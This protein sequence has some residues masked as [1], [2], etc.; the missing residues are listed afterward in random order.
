MSASG[1][2]YVDFALASPALFRLVFG[3][4]LTVHGSPGLEAAGDAALGHLAADL[5]RLRGAV[6]FG[7]PEAWDEVP[8]QM[9]RWT[10][11]GGRELRGLVAR[12]RAEIELMQ[13]I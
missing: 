4:G 3:S 7:Y 9:L 8:A 13:S 6:P 1:E 2:G 12:R 11:A 5:A 10:R